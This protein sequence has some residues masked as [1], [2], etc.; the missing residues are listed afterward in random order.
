MSLSAISSGDI[1]T[2]F[3]AW[4]EDDPSPELYRRW[5]AITMVAGAL[6]RRVWLRTGAYRT[7]PNLYTMLV[8]A[9]G[10]GKGIVNKTKNLMRKVQT[11]DGKPFFSISFDTETP[12]GLVDSLGEAEKTFEIPGGR[13]ITYSYFLVAEE[14]GQIMPV[15]DM[16]FVSLLNGLY[17]NT[18]SYAARTRHGKPPIHEIKWGVLNFLAGVQPAYIASQFPE[19]TWTTGLGRRCMMIFDDTPM[20]YTNPFLETE[21]IKELEPPLLESLSELSTWYGQIEWGKEAMEAMIEWWHG[22]QARPVPGHSKLTA[23]NR[24]RQMNLL[25]LCT[26]SMASRKGE[27]FEISLLDFSRAKSW[28]LEAE[29]L[30][31]DIFRAMIGRSD[32]QVLEELHIFLIARWQSTGQQSVNRTILMQFLAA[33]V[34][35]NKAIEI[36]MQA[37]AAGYLRRD[38]SKP[39]DWY[40]PSPKITRGPE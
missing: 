30:M 26:V 29:A 5:S 25:K 13:K 11:R 17:N 27:E 31:P 35:G 37:E 8:G 40:L 20:R 7:F 33:M 14:F 34:P 32:Y 1:I 24:N 18:P 12:Q 38:G 4:T 2:D 23:Y 22:K 3:V 10:V 15:F 16:Y 39:G 21:G 9:P 28:L 36:M 19:E 6:E